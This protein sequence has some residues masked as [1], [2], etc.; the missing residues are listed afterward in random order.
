VVRSVLKPFLLLA[1]ISVTGILASSC[2]AD[3]SVQSQPEEPLTTTTTVMRVLPSQ[4]V[5]VEYRDTSVDVA[6]FEHMVGRGSLVEDAWYDDGTQY[7]IID[8]GDAFY[9]YCAVPALTWNEFKAADS[10]GTYYNAELKGGSFDCR[11]HGAPQYDSQ[12]FLVAAIPDVTSTTAVDMEWPQSPETWMILATQDYLSEWSLAL[13]DLNWEAD[14]LREGDLNAMGR[15]WLERDYHPALG[16]TETEIRNKA[17]ATF[18]PDGF[19]FSSETTMIADV[20]TMQLIGFDSSLGYLMTYDRDI[21]TRYDDGEQSVD[22]PQ[23]SNV[24]VDP[25]TETAYGAWTSCS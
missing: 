2:S 19:F 18:N 5:D 12:G 25:A 6:D 24:I 7:L 11:I 21:V 20:A 13:N 10:L 3:S 8:L 17:G 16:C 22:G 1:A 15:F 9:D 14:Y 4:P 23:V